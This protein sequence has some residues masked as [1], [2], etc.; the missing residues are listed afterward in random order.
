MFFQIEKLILWPKNKEKAPR[1][2]EFALNKVNLITGASKTGKSAI[3]PIIDYCLGSTKC[4]IPVNTIRDATLWYGIQ[5]KTAHSRILI[6]RKDPLANKQTGQAFI[7]EADEIKL[8]KV[9][10]SQNEKVDVIKEKL[11][12]LCGLSNIDFD[13]HETN[14][15]DKKRASFRDLAAFNYQ[16]QN[17]V[18]NPNALFYK[19]DS[20]DHREKLISI[21]PYVLGAMTND[22]LENLHLLKEKEAELQR[23]ERRFKRLEQQNLDWVS[24]IKA[25][26]AK[27][28][29]MGLLKLSN[30]IDSISPENLL[31]L[32]R[33]IVDKKPD[34]V[35]SASNIK[36]IS[37]QEKKLVQKTRAL[38]N[39]LTAIKGRLDAIESMKQ[40]AK[41]HTNS[42]RIKRE[43]LHLS[44]WLQEKQTDKNSLF[45]SSHEIRELF[46]EPLVK[47][48]EKLESETKVPTN[49]EGAFSREYVR[50]TE[51]LNE[52]SNLLRL[53]KEELKTLRGDAQKEGY[54]TFSVGHFLGQLETV[55]KNIGDGND[56]SELTKQLSLIKKQVG[57]LRGKVNKQSLEYKKQLQLDKVNLLTTNWLPFLDTE[58][59]TAPVKL[60][61][62]ELTLSIN[63]NNRED[64]LWEI[65]S[66]ANWVSYHIAL[67]LALQQHF[68]NLENC[69]VPNY[70]IYDQ[71][72]QVYFPSKL[73]TV[74]ESDDK[75]LLD[76]ELLDEDVHQVQKMFKVMGQAIE[77][78]GQNLQ[79]IVLDHAPSE[80]IRNINNGHLV[81]EWRNGV[82]LIPADWL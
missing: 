62:N 34:A 63:N 11:N 82:K 33:S 5:I 43:R 39:E 67:S 17:I 59:P 40:A 61:D 66:G 19:A 76:P 31:K 2:I 35:V 69:P 47:T 71:P 30:D 9:I 48:F 12:L 27:A 18:A 55:L 4:T 81:Q 3:I 25:Y 10:N 78:T 36:F 73:T 79:V 58:N 64:Y 26:A 44:K 75:K 32:L 42:S 21:F 72:S 57:N 15:P 16:P 50:L 46:L 7:L 65:G 13:F 14:R 52:K 51:Q 53:A 37:Q 29:G 1:V 77:K 70:I 38:S 56:E 74:S 41:S 45:S 24:Q 23:I 28:L 49:V 8:P 60:L 68:A 22:D 6:A 54:D 80:L 20:H